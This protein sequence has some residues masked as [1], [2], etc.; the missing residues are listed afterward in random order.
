MIGHHQ[1]LDHHGNRFGD[2]ILGHHLDIQSY[3]SYASHGENAA[4]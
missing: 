4:K 3:E 2:P 1:H